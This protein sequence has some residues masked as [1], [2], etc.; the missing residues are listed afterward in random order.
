MDRK[1]LKIL[2]FSMIFPYLD[3]GIS[4]WGSTHTSYLENLQVMQKKAIRLISGAPYNA[5]TSPLFK[6]LKM[7]NLKDMFLLSI[8][9]LMYQ[10]SQNTLP[11]PLVS[12]FQ[13]NSNIHD[14]NTRNKDS[15]HFEKR[16]TELAMKSLKHTGPKIWSNIPNNIKASK[17]QRTF[18]NKLKKYY[19]NKYTS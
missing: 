1:H 10:C 17:T 7:L 18:I 2:Y 4:L 8:S 19:I 5:H 12:M 11:S 16:R 9:K 15:F 13:L 14:H 3:Y 6:Q